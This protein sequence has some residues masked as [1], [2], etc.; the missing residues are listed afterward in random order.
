MLR[1]QEELFPRPMQYMASRRNLHIYMMLMICYGLFRKTGGMPGWRLKQR[2]PRRR[3]RRR[4]RAMKFLRWVGAIAAE[5]SQHVESAERRAPSAERRAPS[6]ERRAP[7]AERRGHDCASGC[8]SRPTRHRR[9][10]AGRPAGA[11]APHLLHMPHPPPAGRRVPCA[12]P[13]PGA[14]SSAPPGRSPPRRCSRSPAPSPSPRS[15]QAQTAIAL[16]SNIG[17]GVTSVYHQCH[18]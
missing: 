15:A 18:Q 3:T 11:A 17:L 12:S 14:G 10:T 7:S 2:G 8:G 5:N 9:L 6:A 16:V 4:A 1:G 13:V